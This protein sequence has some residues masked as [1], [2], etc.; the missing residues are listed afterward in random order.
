[1]VTAA[2]RLLL[3]AFALASSM[4]AGCD[5]AAPSPPAVGAALV[6]VA[7]ASS[8]RKALAAIAEEY[9]RRHPGVRID[10]VGG[11]TATLAGQLR[12]G[13]PFD[14]F[15]AADRATADALARDGVLDGRTVEVYAQGELVLWLRGPAGPST[16][17]ADHHALS[18]KSIRRLALA[19]ERTAPYGRAARQVLVRMKP[20]NDVLVVTGESVEQAAHFASTG[21]VDAA[22]LPRGQA[23]SITATRGRVASIDPGWY[24]PLE[25]AGGVAARSQGAPAS[26]AH[27][28]HAF[29]LGE[30]GQEIIR[31]SGFV[32]RSNGGGH[33]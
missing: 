21:A 15:Y 24:D 32:I 31:R 14:L 2:R 8:A 19:D 18:D 17:V 13:A 1:M 29:V 26:A 11:S 6:R 25:Q 23:E 30:Q 16:G 5:R 4:T 22:L 12:A 20:H 28:F 7:V 3:V 33:D 27:A 10:V 9:A